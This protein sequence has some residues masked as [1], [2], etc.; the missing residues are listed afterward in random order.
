MGFTLLIVNSGDTAHINART[1]DAILKINLLIFS[2]NFRYFDVNLRSVDGGIYERDNKCR[3][4]ASCIYQDNCPE[5]LEKRK[6]LKDFPRDSQEYAEALE[7]IKKSV[8]N[9]SEKGV[10][11]PHPKQKED[12]RCGKGSG[13]M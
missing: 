3:G 9:R 8:C 12:A 5:F 11:C 13:I 6:Y 1:G 4:G 7:K 2:L 10:C